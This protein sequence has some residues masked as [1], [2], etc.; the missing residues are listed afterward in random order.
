MS[1]LGAGQPAAPPR[2]I[3]RPHSLKYRLF[4]VIICL[5]VGI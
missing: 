1:S 5:D 3:Y 4:K 2:P